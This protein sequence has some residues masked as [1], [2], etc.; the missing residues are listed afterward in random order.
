MKHFIHV[1]VRVWERQYSAN[2]VLRQRLECALDNA[3]GFGL[4]CSVGTRLWGRKC[5]CCV[6]GVN[7]W[8]AMDGAGVLLR[9]HWVARL[10][11]KGVPS[12]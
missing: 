6:H 7:I 9:L 1:L 12:A 8:W 2:K 4:M 3:E 5:G 10:L 11:V